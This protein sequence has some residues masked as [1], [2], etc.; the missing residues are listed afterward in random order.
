MF[1]IILIAVIVYFVVKALNKNKAGGST[2]S[3]PPTTTYTPVQPTAPAPKPTTPIKPAAPKPAAPVK[4]SD[5]ASFGGFDTSAFASAFAAME[6]KSVP[7]DEPAKPATPVVDESADRKWVR[8]HEFTEDICEFY[9]RAWGP[10]GKIYTKI[11]S[12][13]LPIV[14]LVITVGPEGMHETLYLKEGGDFESDTTFASFEIDGAYTTLDTPAKRSELLKCI[15][16]RLATLP[17]ITVKSDGFH[18]ITGVSAPAPQPEPVKSEPKAEPKS[19]PFGGESGFGNVDDAFSAVSADAFAQAFAQMGGDAPKKAE[20]P[21]PAPAP[22]PAADNSADS[23]PELL[24]AIAKNV[25]GYYHTMWNKESGALYT[26]L[27]SSMPIDHFSFQAKE[28][29]L[30]E[31]VWLIGDSVPLVTETAYEK[32]CAGDGIATP[33]LRSAKDR[34]ELELLLAKYLVDELGTVTLKGN[35]FYPIR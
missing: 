31:S 27:N 21:A 10:E 3:V 32:L 4:S 11:N 20:E 35:D 17:T 15:T 28:S 8:E 5:S 22:A 2:K 14:R 30:V 33:V 9:H 1:E 23:D 24:K 16:E 13:E 19:D 34:K 29:C 6:G 7:A 25:L 12:G 26:E 18:V